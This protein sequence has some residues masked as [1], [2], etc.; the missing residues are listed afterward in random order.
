MFLGIDLNVDIDENKDVTAVYAKGFGSTRFYLIKYSEGQ[1]YPEVVSV[2]KDKKLTLNIL[3]RCL[4]PGYGFNGNF[5]IK[6]LIP[7]RAGKNIYMFAFENI[8]EEKAYNYYF[9]ARKGK[10]LSYKREVRSIK[11]ELNR[12]AKQQELLKVV[13]SDEEAE[14]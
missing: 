3:Q 9:I 13:E 7:G 2:S 12:R 11:R 1:N 6:E 5:V 14:K 10:G 4:T 8:E